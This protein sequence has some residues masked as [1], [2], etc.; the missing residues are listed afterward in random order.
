MEIQLLPIKVLAQ[1][2]PLNVFHRYETRRVFLTKFINGQDIGMIESG[3]CSCFPDEAA[4]PF[5]I[6]GDFSRQ[7]LDSYSSAQLARILSQVNLAHSTRADVRAN[8]VTSKF[9]SG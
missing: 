3:D 6:G 1:G 5:L 2:Y 8:F 9:C 4:Q 7:Q